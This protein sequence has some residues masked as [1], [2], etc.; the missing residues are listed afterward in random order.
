MIFWRIWPFEC[1]ILMILTMAKYHENLLKVSSLSFLFIVKFFSSLKTRMILK[2]P[3]ETFLRITQYLWSYCFYPWTRVVV[4]SVCWMLL[5]RFI[6]FILA[7][8]KSTIY[9]IVS[10][11]GL[12]LLWFIKNDN[13]KKQ[14]HPETVNSAEWKKIGFNTENIALS[15]CRFQCTNMWNCWMWLACLPMEVW[16]ESCNHRRII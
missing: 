9:N 7:N 10:L 6:L 14:D 16:D 15:A 13:N 11:K 4:W 2:T 5:S 3:N 1:L 12:A 8:I